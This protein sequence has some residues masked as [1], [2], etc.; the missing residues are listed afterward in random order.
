MSLATEFASAVPIPVAARALSLAPAAPPSELPAGPRA[1]SLASVTVLRPA[2]DTSTPPLR[3]TRRGVAALALMVAAL[4]ALL[5]WLAARSAPSA[6]G[7]ATAPVHGP[8]VVTVAQGDTLWSIASRV[9]PDRDPRSEV[10]SLQRL[11]R[12][13]AVSLVPGQQLRVR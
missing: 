2:A 13:S 9:A 4:G 3:L 6:P 8:A 7:G 10:A 5:L 12:L 1:G 11:N